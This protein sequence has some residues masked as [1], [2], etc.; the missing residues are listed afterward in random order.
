MKLEIKE[1]FSI[2]YE[3]SVFR[4]YVDSFMKDSFQSEELA[5][6]ALERLKQAV[7][8]TKEPRLVYSEEFQ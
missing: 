3:K 8:N 2:V 6:D 5:M 7:I 1:E 4:L